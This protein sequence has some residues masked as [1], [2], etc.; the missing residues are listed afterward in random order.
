MRQNSANSSLSSIGEEIVI[1]MTNMTW[2]VEL[3]IKTVSEANSSE[4]WTKKSK[5]HRQQQLLLKIAFMNDNPKITLPCTIKF[6][7]LAKRK[8]DAHDNLPMSFKYLADRLASMILNE[9]GQPGQ[10]DNDPRITWQ[11]DQ[12]SAK[13]YAII[14]EITSS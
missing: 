7:R 11:Y 5:R 8:L 2:K 13:Y 6:T 9:D 3:P 14:I 12:I 4:H 1:K 10:G